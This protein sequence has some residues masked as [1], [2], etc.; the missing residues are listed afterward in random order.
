M[1]TPGSQVRERP[2]PA[3]GGTPDPP[4]PGR[5]RPSILD[6]GERFGLVVILVLEIAF[7]VVLEPETFGTLANAR[8]VT[9]SISVLAVL[10][11]G[12]ML[13][14][15]GGRFDV[16]TGAILCVSSVATAS[17]MSRYGLPLGVAI[18]IGLVLG[19]AIG[20]LNGLVIAYLGV[21]SIIA[22]IGTGT[23]LV[24]LVQAYTEGLP[25]QNGLSPWLVELG[26]Q[27]LLGVPTLFLI[28]VVVCFASWY[29][30]TQTPWGRF[31][32]AT[33]SNLNAARLNGIPARRI[34]FQSFVVSG[35]LAGIGGI[36]QIAAQGSGDPSIGGIPFI[37]PAL[38]A[39]FLG[40]TTLRPG[41]YNVGGTLLALIFIATTISGLILVGLKPW[42]TDVFNGGAVVV[43]IAISA[44]VRRR[45]TGSMD[46]GG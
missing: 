24:G 41:R 23:V 33:G 44:Q 25:V 6:L 27:N 29:L 21:N 34:V 30:I 17:A 1:T 43:A 31:L 7:F 10:A 38:A 26:N 40:A 3:D 28:A 11:M 2:H 32:T 18:I 35:L 4:V 39:V 8:I 36:M 20:A 45:R 15:L 13:P 19:C 16:S 22:T 42:V 5:R 14:L 12:L 46:V 9:T 37:L